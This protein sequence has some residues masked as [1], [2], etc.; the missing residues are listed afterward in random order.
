MPTSPLSFLGQNH[1]L[2]K[3]GWH[4]GPLWAKPWDTS[5]Y[6]EITAVSHDR[7]DLVVSFGDGSQA[8]VPVS[9]LQA[10][11]LNDADWPALRFTPDEVVVPT[12]AGDVEI[13]W[14]SLRALTDAEFG[15]YLDRFAA[16]EARR[17]GTTRP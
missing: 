1:R 8:R 16:D 15:A 6:G 11:H 3:K 9:Q 17:V 13:S 4:D 5:A 14:F 7:G 2:P 10:L 12:A